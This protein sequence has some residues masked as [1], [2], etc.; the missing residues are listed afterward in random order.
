MN[1]EFDTD[2]ISQHMV[3]YGVH[4]QPTIMLKENKTK[5]LDYCNWL[6]EQ[7]PEVFETLLS[8]P[9]QLRVQ[10]NFAVSGNRRIDMP[11]FMLTNRGPL[12]TF[13]QR[14]YIDQPHDVDIPRKD[15]IFRKALD[16]LM[17][18]FSDRSIQ[19]VGVIHELV[20][21]TEEINS[22]EII[23]SNLKSE[24]WREK[25]RNMSIRLETPTE[26]K[27]IHVEIRPTHVT[28]AGRPDPNTAGQNMLFGIIVNVDINNRQI[29]PN[30]TKPEINDIL[31]FADDY[32]PEQLIRFLNNEY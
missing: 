24:V 13:P 23:A 25:V 6:I 7:S 28:R 26:D 18:R 14:I 27:N 3:K 20:F 1:Y 31:A 16:E 30:L 15:K 17:A 2:K 8:G 4:L 9:N 22:L 11:T 12:F 10:K 32:V 21:D 19:R 5:L 29:K